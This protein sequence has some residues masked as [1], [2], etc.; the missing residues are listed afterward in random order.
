MNDELLNWEEAVQWLKEQPDQE[1]TVRDCYYDDPLDVA[2]ERFYRSEEWQAVANIAKAH[3]SSGKVLDLGAG[4]GISSYAFAKM[5]YSTTALEPDPSSLVGAKAIQA[6]VESSQIPI[7]IVQGQAE[8]LPFSDCSFDIVYGRA[9]LHHARDLTKLCQE[10]ARILKPNGILIA[11]REHII[12]K[13]EDLDEFLFSHPLHFLYGGESAYLLSEYIDKIQH[14]GLV[15][16]Q[17]IA[18]FDNVIN[19]APMSQHEFYEMTVSM[20]ANRVSQPIAKW[21]ASNSQLQSL[22]GR[23]L[24]YKSSSP[25]RLYSFVAIKK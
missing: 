3:V 19:Y 25:G 4:R 24:S 13:L 17:V 14:S 6:L 21:L 2:A 9:V 7:Q 22:Y 20:L 18:P 11:T 5:G 23:Y 16:Q 10:A 12:S 8:L 1:K 15:M